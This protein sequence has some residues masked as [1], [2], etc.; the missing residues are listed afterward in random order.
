M[1][2]PCTPLPGLWQ[3][4]AHWQSVLSDPWQGPS[5][6]RV[7][8]QGEWSEL[9]HAMEKEKRTGAGYTTRWAFRERVDLHRTTRRPRLLAHTGHSPAV[10]SLE[11]ARVPCRRWSQLYPQPAA[12]VN[13]GP[14]WQYR[15][16]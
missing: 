6:P 5:I 2:Q 1:L 10:V 11:A 7:P 3:K 12:G 8:P 16:R 13:S 9:S 15:S 4:R 14:R